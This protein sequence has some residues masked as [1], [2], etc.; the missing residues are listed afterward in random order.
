M[1]APIASATD[2]RE[3]PRRKHTLKKGLLGAGVA[4]A[5]WLQPATA[6]NRQPVLLTDAQMDAVTAGGLLSSSTVMQASA[7]GPSYAA[8]ATDTSTVS[9]IMP[10]IGRTQ[11]TGRSTSISDGVAGTAGLSTSVAD[12]AAVTV[13]GAATAVGDT[14]L[15]ETTVYTRGVDTQYANVSIGVVTSVAC[16]GPAT[17]TT[18]DGAGI[19]AGDRGVVRVVSRDVTTPW[20]S[21]SQ[22]VVVAISVDLPRPVTR[23][24]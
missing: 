2:Q 1:S 7:V 16:C 18:T 11:G 4:L 22:T 8:A 17:A 19:A 13:A 24:W 14:A 5:V 10:R 23:Q 9:R 3:M 15:A 21:R 12:T 6:E 20:F